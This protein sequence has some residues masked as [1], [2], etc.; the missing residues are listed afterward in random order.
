MFKKIFGSAPSSDSSLWEPLTS[1]EQLTA[2][3]EQSATQPVLIFKHSTRCS[4]SSMA[5]SRLK[6]A[7]EPLQEAGFK[8]VL[9]DLIR[10]RELSNRIAEQFSVPHQSPQVVVV[11]DGKAIYDASHTE[12]QPETLIAQQQP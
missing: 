4:I 8:L 6:R 12:I 5:L 2:L 10:Y 3:Q 1:T 7:S 9:L 11:R